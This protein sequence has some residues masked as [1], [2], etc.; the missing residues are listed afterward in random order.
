[1][2]RKRVTVLGSTGSVGVQAL[3]VV[4]RHPDRLEIASLAAGSNYALLANQAKTWKPSVV[5]L[6]TESAANALRNLLDA[7]S[8]EVVWGDDGLMLVT[9]SVDTDIVLNAVVGAAGLAATHE[10]VSR[11]IDV[12]LA[13]VRNQHFGTR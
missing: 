7:E 9:T 12:A 5:S 1:M 3:D 6:A 10:A 2:P 11:G 13:N 8:P 4:A